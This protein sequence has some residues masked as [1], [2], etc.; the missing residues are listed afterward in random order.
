[1][2]GT[3]TRT[4]EALRHP[5]RRQAEMLLALGVRQ[6]KET[7]VCAQPDGSPLSLRALSKA[8]ASL[9]AG[10]K[11]P[12]RLHD[13]RH[14]HLSHLLAAGVHPKV[15]SERAGHA[16]V[17]IALDVYSHLIPARRIDAALRTHLER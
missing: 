6:D 4:V 7:L 3:P 14:S 12:I 8:F 2:I 16:S 15:A 17:S 10:M 5:R 9:V 1:V 13:L 11:L